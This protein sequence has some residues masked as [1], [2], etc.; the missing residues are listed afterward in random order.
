MNQNCKNKLNSLYEMRKNK[1]NSL[2]GMRKNKLFS[3]Y[4]M[5]AQSH[6]KPETQFKQD[7][8]C[9]LKEDYKEKVDSRFVYADTDSVKYLVEN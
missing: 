8:F 3:L 2:Y 5:S 1:L 9:I 6:I 7:G 4:G